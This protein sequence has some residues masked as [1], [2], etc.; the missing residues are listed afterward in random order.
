MI[1]LKSEEVA[2][3]ETKAEFAAAY[4]TLLERMFNTFEEKG[5]TRDICSP[6]NHR[7][8]PFGMLSIAQ[9]KCRRIE[10]LLSRPEWEDHSITLKDITEEC[11]D[12][13]NYVLYLAALCSLLGE[14][15]EQK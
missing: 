5:K 3:A 8:S 11:V 2:F 13:A 4:T 14:E 7:Q 1:Y 10:A 15:E 9:A 6:L 12:V